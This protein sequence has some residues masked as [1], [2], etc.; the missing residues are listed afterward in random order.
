[1][2]KKIMLLAVAALATMAFAV[3]ALASAEG[4]AIY[5]VKTL[6]TAAEETKI[7]LSGKVGFVGE[8]GGFSECT[9]NGTLVV[10]EESAA[11][12]TNIAV[13]PGC[14]GF[15]VFKGCT[16]KEAAGETAEA[17]ITGHDI[18]VFNLH[19]TGT[20]NATCGLEGVGLSG[21]LE[22]VTLDFEVVTLQPKEGS[23][24][25]LDCLTVSSTGG[26]A[27]TGIGKLP[28]SANGTIGATLSDIGTWAIET[29]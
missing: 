17:T 9:I 15:G 21:A 14:A 24:T 18:D 25:S 22:H 1:M 10:G 8:K 20:N 16:V 29:I 6:E 27:T 4:G 28:V 13:V 2:F 23:E 19:I 26:V 12:L 5:D 11:T 7:E 3:P